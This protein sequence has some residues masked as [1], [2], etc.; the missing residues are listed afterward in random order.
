MIY[1]DLDVAK[2]LNK[3]VNSIKNLDKDDLKKLSNYA[4]RMSNMI[5]SDGLVRSILFAFSKAKIV[6]I[7]VYISNINIKERSLNDSMRWAIVT[8]ILINEYFSDC[9]DPSK[10]EIDLLVLLDKLHRGE[11]GNID[12]LEQ[13]IIQCLDTLSR[14]LESYLREE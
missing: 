10:K 13:K 6:N 5:M 2:R 14:I 9:I 3:Y 1:V 11:L 4:K 12:I 8:G 7:N